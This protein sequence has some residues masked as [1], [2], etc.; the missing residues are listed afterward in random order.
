V[1]SGAVSERG[2]ARLAGISQPHMHN[3]LK[4]IRALSLESAD[5]LMRALDVTIPLV[6]W[7]GAGMDLARIRAVPVLRSPI[8]PGATVGF[9]AFRGY[10]PFPVTLAGHL[11][12]PLAAYLA[13]DLALPSEYRAGDA[14]LMDL[15]PAMRS[16]PAPSS[17][18]IVAES[19]GLR[20]RYVRRVRGGVEVASGPGMSAARDWQT[21]SLQGRNILEIVRARIVWIGR[22]MEAPLAGPPR[23]A[24][25]GD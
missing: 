25:A 18:W 6:V 11:E 15:N 23:P 9:D 19:A 3:V 1:R 21:I 12:D 7:Y 22:E 17:C 16:A 10:M 2:L 13:A 24:R 20:V 14:I 4:G 8:G 5:C